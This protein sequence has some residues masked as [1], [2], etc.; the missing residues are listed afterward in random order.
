MNGMCVLVTQT[1]KSSKRSCRRSLTGQEPGNF[2]D[3]IIFAVMFDYIT[4]KSLKVQD[5]CPAQAKEGA[6]YAASFRLCY[7][8]FCGPGSEKTWTYNQDQPSY[9]F[10]DGE[11][12]N[13]AL[14]LIS[15]FLFSKHPVFKC[16][17]ILQTDVL[18]K[19]KRGG[20]AGT[21]FKSEPDAREFDIGV[22]SSLSVSRSTNVDSEK[23]VS[24]RFLLPSWN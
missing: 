9:Q 4:W 7:W 19:R 17:N 10:A 14:R 12:D 15:E 22:Q 18:M 3:R 13:F 24:S 1:C 2:L 21:H 5:Q 16:S 23:D 11:W 6:T 20:G 8:C